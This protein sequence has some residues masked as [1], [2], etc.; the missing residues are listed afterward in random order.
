MKDYYIVLNW[1]AETN[2]VNALICNNTKANV[3]KPCPNLFPNCSNRAGTK[4]HQTQ[5]VIRQRQ[6]GFLCKF[7]K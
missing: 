4:K 2:I 7:T 5:R 6:F 3:E 1:V